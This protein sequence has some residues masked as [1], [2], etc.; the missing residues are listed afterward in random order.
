ME[1]D[2][3]LLPDIDEQGH[4][5]KE[6]EASY[7]GC[8]FT[9]IGIVVLAIIALLLMPS[10]QPPEPIIVVKHD[11]LWRDS[12]VREPAPKD[13]TP[14]GRIVYVR[15]PYPVTEPGDTV[16]D[17]IQVP[18]PIIQKRYDDSLYTAWVSGYQPA[19][20]SILLHQREI[21]TTITK[22][23]V[24]KAPRLSVGLS[25]GPGVS[26]DSEHHLGIYVGLTANYRLWPK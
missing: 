22:T 7:R 25:V 26:I 23:I 3:D 14:T 9:S 15:V 17:S 1:K 4:T 18:L 2:K 12:I 21:T 20:D 16:H 10:P 24:K 13:S 8:F 5:D 6:L 11:T 19:L